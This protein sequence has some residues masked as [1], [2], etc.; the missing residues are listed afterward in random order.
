ML[1]AVAGFDSLVDD[2]VLRLCGVLDDQRMNRNGME[3]FGTLW[4]GSQFD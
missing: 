4:N 2:N 1:A 3:R